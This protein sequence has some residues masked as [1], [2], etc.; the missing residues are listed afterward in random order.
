MVDASALWLNR[1]RDPL[2][3]RSRGSFHVVSTVRERAGDETGRRSLVVLGSRSAERACVARALTDIAEAHR[4]VEHPR[5]P[6]VVELGEHEGTPFLELACDA[7]VDGNELLRVLADAGQKLSYGQGDALFTSLRE[8][9]QAGHRV[10][11]PRSGRPYCF[12]RV[13]YGN[14]LVSRSG[15][16]W[17]VGL[18]H[19]FPLLKEDG[20]VEGLGSVWQAPEVMS[21]EAPTPVSDYVAVLMIVR[22]LTAFCDMG[23]LVQRFFFHVA[24]SPESLEAYELAR[25]FETQ[26]ISQRPDRRPSIEE[27]IA[28]SQRLRAIMGVKMDLEGLEA[29]LASIIAASDGEARD[30]ADG[31]LIR[32]PNDGEWIQVGEGERHRLGR[33]NGQVLR[34]L[35][36]ALEH[37]PGRALGVW[38][39]LEA[40]WP[41]EDPIPE[42]GANRVYA[43]IARLRTLGLRNV[44]Q[45]HGEGYRLVPGRALKVTSTSWL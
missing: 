2:P 31:E 22:S 37:E 14:I 12:G 21:G 5:I 35:L 39:L 16:F 40:G 3:V 10:I 29:R 41:G 26:F 15:R 20:R 44:L 11:D 8:A 33:A 19:N 23:E 30:P 18:G 34:A 42:A 32:V 36:R 17:F 43:S 6:R 38:Q 24:L 25:W 1:Y 45:R 27:G 9:M 4:R 13:G 28:K 7:V